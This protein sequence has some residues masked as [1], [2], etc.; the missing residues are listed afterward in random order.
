EFRDEDVDWL[1]AV[2]SSSRLPAGTTLIRQGVPGDALFVVLEGQLVVET[3]GG[4]RLALL[5]AGELVGELSFLDSRP[6]IASVRA[7]RDTALL[8]LPVRRMLARLRTDVGFASRFYRG[9]GV[10]LAD[11]LRETD[12]QLLSGAE[13]QGAEQG[14]G[15]EE[16]IAELLDK[17][18]LAAA[19][20]E[21]ISR[22]LLGAH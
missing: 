16:I 6:P 3:E 11:R 12:L 10:F 21:L 13:A 22:R 4:Q 7:L 19:R 9:L 2:G 5:G 15:S 20:F 8:V 1:L 18:D 17:L 14:A